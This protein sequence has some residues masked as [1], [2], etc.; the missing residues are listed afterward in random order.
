MRIWTVILPLPLLA[1]AACGGDGPQTIGGSLAPTG[2]NTTTVNGGTGSGVTAGSGTSAPTTPATS[3]LSNLTTDKSYDAIGGFHTLNETIAT[4][5]STSVLYEGNATTVH[6]PTGQ[7]SYSPRDGIFTLTLSDTKAGID[8]TVRFQDPAHRTDSP[9]IDA[10]T[11]DGFNYLTALNASTSATQSDSTTFFYQRPGTSTVYV[12]LAGFVRD[13]TL[14]DSNPISQ[15]GAF[16]FGDQTVRSQ[17]PTSGTGSYTGGFL[18]SMVNDPDTGKGS[19]F[20]WIQGDSSL[21][22]DFTKSTVAMSLS[23]K[24]DA[25]SL[26]NVAIPDSKLAIPTGSSFSATGSAMIDLVKTGGF[27]GTFSDVHFVDTA[28]NK[29]NVDFSAISAGSSTAGASSIDGAFYGPN[30]VNLG[31]SFRVTGGIPNQRVDILGAFTG[32]KK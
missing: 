25:A 2:S 21:S 18:A 17:I 23:G 1:L 6:T 13:N 28:G 31:G 15:R 14:S 32:A 26:N 29:V 27:T 12:S 30:A 8:N 24:V 3:F 5:G 20:Q 4:D 7:V 9:T 10:P 16:V 22:V 11:L 19:Y